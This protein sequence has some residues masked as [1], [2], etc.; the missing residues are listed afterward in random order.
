MICGEAC[1]GAE[2]RFGKHWQRYLKRQVKKY[3]L[4]FAKRN[5]TALCFSRSPTV[6]L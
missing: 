6:Y 4:N 2:E 3:R 1:R 5:S